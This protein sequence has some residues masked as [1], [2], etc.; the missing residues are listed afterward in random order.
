MSETRSKKHYDLC[1][2]GGGINGAGVARD[3]AGRGLS[4]LLVEARD[5]TAATSS[6]S[7]KL[8]HGGL[9]YLEYFEFGLVRDSLKER[10][11]L[12]RLAPHIIQPMSF[13]LPHD[14]GQRPWWMIRL[15]LFLYDNLARRKMLPGSQGIDFH[16]TGAGEPL[17]EHF[18]KGFKYA[19][20]W[21]DDARLV[22]LNAMSAA[23]KGADILTQTKCIGIEDGRQAWTVRLED[24]AGLTFEVSAEALVNATGPW[25]RDVIDG[26]GLAQPDTPHIRL[27]KGSHIIIK[28]AYEGDQAYILQQPD[29]RIVFVIPYEGDYTLIGTTEEAFE[30]DSYEA[31]ISEE[32]MTYLCEAYNRAFKAP[33]SRSDLLWTYSGVRPLFDD[34]EGEARAVTRDYKIYEQPSTPHLMLSVFGGKLTTYRVL[35]EEVVDRIVEVAG[36][37][38]PAWTALENLPGG[39][40]AAADFE[41][42]LDVQRKEYSWLEEG[43]LYRY[44]RS[45]GAR[46]DRFLEGA[47]SIDD[48]GVHY[49]GGLYEAELRYLVRHE[50]ARCAEDVLWRRSKLG[51][52][53]DKDTAARLEA[54]LPDI[55]GEAE[56]A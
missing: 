53:V 1:V 6:A 31:R 12:L 52:H 17:K 39:G 55:L 10:E 26:S 38:V 34:G 40:I 8:I 42:F 24:A 15:G 36:R 48:L 14:R 27:V 47:G 56:Q 20:C 50:W 41:A 18:K 43:L 2:I 16:K 51:A 23:E 5:L 54:A 37:D 28:R 44:A 35:A 21:V 11:T 29:K 30:G 9:R 33:I 3:A 49:G 32:E 13:V 19:D 46:M 45:Y 4:V 25:V 7:T 22:V